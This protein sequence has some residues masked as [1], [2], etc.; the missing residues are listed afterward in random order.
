MTN[1]AKNSIAFWLETKAA[2]AKQNRGASMMKIIVADSSEL[3]EV[4]KDLTTE[5]E[6]GTVEITLNGISEIVER[7]KT[8]RDIALKQDVSPIMLED[9]ISAIRPV[10]MAVEPEE[11]EAMGSMLDKRVFEDGQYM[12]RPRKPGPMSSNSDP[13]AWP[14]GTRATGSLRTRNVPRRWSR[15][16]SAID[17]IGTPERVM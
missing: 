3:L 16:R 17:T 4:G 15:K 9:G 14:V 8:H 1:D 13:Y 10:K 5:Q 7:M 2:V 11:M 6:I 12:S